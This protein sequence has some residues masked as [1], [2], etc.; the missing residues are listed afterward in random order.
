MQI[1]P[2]H[3]HLEW[4]KHLAGRRDSLAWV[5]ARSEEGRETSLRILGPPDQARVERVRRWGGKSVDLI[6][7]C[8]TSGGG[9]VHVFL[10]F[11]S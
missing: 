5:S 9:E 2:S 4:R 7:L 8:V 6:N 1:I 11:T 3:H 10:S